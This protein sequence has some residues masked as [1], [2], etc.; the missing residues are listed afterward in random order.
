[1]PPSLFLEDYLGYPDLGKSLTVLAG[2]LAESLP[3]PP[4][5]QEIGL[6][7]PSVLEAAQFLEKN[8]PGMKTFF[9]GTGSPTHFAENG[10]EIPFTTR[11][12]FGFYKGV[13]FELAE[14]GIGSEIFAQTDISSGKIMINHLG[15]F[16]HG[17]ELIWKNNNQSVSYTQVMQ[18]AQIPKRVD[19]ILSLLGITAHINI[20]ETMHL[21]HGVEIEFLDFRLFSPTGPAINYPSGLVAFLGWWQKHIGPRFL[22]MKADQ[23]LPP[24]P[25]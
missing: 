9:L 24:E 14:P 17:P 12:G 15:Y 3:L 19:G 5:V 13:L 23:P 10:K 8:Y 25:Q 18:R 2:N 22:Q 21:T 1:M 6:V 4:S 16:A 20:Y 7:C 11:V